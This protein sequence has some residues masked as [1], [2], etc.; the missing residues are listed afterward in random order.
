MVE[1]ADLFGVTKQRAHQH[2]DEPGFPA[3]V[4]HDSRGRLWAGERGRGVGEALAT[5]EALALA[6][7]LHAVG[8]GGVHERLQDSRR[9]PADGSAATR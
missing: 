2:A 6:H 1:I 8:V 3:A 4:E 5:R 9:P 7:E